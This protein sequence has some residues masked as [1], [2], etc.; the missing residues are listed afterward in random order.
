MSMEHTKLNRQRSGQYR[1]SADREAFLDQFNSALQPFEQQEYADIPPSHPFLFVIGLPRS[2]TTLLS[3][4]LVHCLDVGYI[5]NLA[6]RFWRAPVTGIRF[7]DS[8]LETGRFQAFQSHYG[9][10]QELA[11]I[12]EFGYFWREWL[13]KDSFKNIKNARAIEDQIDWGGLRKALANMQAQFNRPMVFKNIF[14]SYHIPKLNNVLEQTLWIYIERDPLDTA[15]SIL[16]A[17]RKYYDDPNNW[18]S[19]VPPQYEQII[20]KDYWHQIAGQIHYLKK[21]YHQ[22]LEDMEDSGRGLSFSYDKLCSNPAGLLEAVTDRVRKLYG[23]EIPITQK[24]PSRFEYSS[25][26]DSTEE[27]QRFKQIL[28]RF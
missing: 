24:P 17:R 22:E 27:K 20:D 10:T 3:Q 13:K 18:W 21:F 7:A 14:G 26:K 9:A 8:V 2:G 11:D 28:E 25:Y 4:L 19:Y 16:E 12:H 1:K 15:V 6:A 23:V 5:N